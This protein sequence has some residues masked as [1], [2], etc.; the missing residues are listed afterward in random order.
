MTLA[1]SS[2][3]DGRALW[4]LARG[5]GA[6]SLVLL[7]LSVALGVADV[8]RWSAPRLPRFVV[9]GLH[10]T[11]SLFVVVTVAIHVI[12]TLLDSFAPIR[13]VDVLVPF[14]SAY[15]PLW[16]GFGALAFD[17]LLALV[18]TSLAR[19]RLGYRGWRAVHWLAYACWPVALLHGL[20]SGSDIRGGFAFVLSL[21]C[22]AAVAIAIVARLLATDGPLGTQVGVLGAIAAA[23]A[24][25]AIWLPAGPLARGWAARAGT[26]RSVLAAA[27]GQSPAPRGGRAGSPATRRAAR[28]AA[29]GL[30]APLTAPV[31]G[32]V[33]EVVN[34]NGSAVV[35][36][37]LDLQKGP[38]TRMNVQ[39][40]GRSAAGGGISLTH[41][42]VAL[43][44]KGRPAT[45]RG[46][47]S[48]L[49]GGQLDARLS[50]KGGSSLAVA[51]ALQIDRSTGHVAG[52]ANLVPAGR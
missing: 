24:A 43:G 7:T 52:T 51:L 28:P 35:Q 39:L 10:R 8:R 9:D 14:V 38:F 42:Q 45:Y 44:T 34:P 48:S 23:V 47:V 50:G 2:Q 5:T 19:A 46:P 21:A 12:T 13:L 49:N 6:V 32:R 37:S 26:P 29:A 16:I 4:Y 30:S 22:A 33:G 1:L 36:L 20:G 27:H 40:F 41:G 15:R 31:T 3:L 18:I 17:L 11:V 25:L